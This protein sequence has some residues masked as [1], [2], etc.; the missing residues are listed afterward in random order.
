M[1]KILLNASNPEEKKIAV[2]SEGR[3]SD[4]ISYLPGTEDRRNNIYRGIV[5]KVEPSLDA[6]FVDIGD[7]KNGFL[8]VSEI[9]ESYLKGSPEQPLNERLEPETPIKVQ[10]IKDS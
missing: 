1:K 4:Y 2:L 3:L 6:C 10:I 7:S 9:D 5:K 8:Q